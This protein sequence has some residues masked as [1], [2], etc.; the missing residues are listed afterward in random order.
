MPKR[1]TPECGVPGMCLKNLRGL[2]VSE[3]ETET[4]AALLLYI[5]NTPGREA[6]VKNQPIT[7]LMLTCLH[8][9]RIERTC[10][11]DKH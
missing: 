6:L 7:S 3:S 1:R 11:L 2:R 10:D 8:I 5:H 9:F 4:A